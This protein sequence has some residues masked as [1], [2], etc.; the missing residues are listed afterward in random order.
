[1]TSDNTTVV[2]AI[3]ASGT[4]P[5]KGTTTATLSGGMATFTNLADNTAETITLQF[6]G[7]G[8]SSAAEQRSSSARRP[9]ASW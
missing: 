1:M 6:T 9:P 2:T 4:G 7:G 5:L 3:L 8:L